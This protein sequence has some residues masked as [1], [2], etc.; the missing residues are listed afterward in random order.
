MV[1][2]YEP[3]D[4]HWAPPP[5][6]PF[7]EEVGADPGPAADRGHRRD[8]DRASASIRGSSRS[9]ASAADALAGLGHDVIE[10][11]PPWRRRERAARVR[12]PVVDR[13]G[14]VPG[15]G[16]L[17]A[18]AAEPR[19]RERGRCASSADYA[20]AV[21]WFQGFARRVVAF[22]ADVDVVLTP[23][24]GMLPVEIGWVTA[25]DDPWEQYRRAGQFT[26]FT[27][28][29]NVTGQPAASVPWTLVDGLP[30]G[31]QLI[32]P[33]AGEALLIRLSSQLEDAYPWARR[34][35]HPEG[36]LGRVSIRGVPRAAR[37]TVQRV[38]NIVRLERELATVELKKKLQELGIGAG[39]LGLPRTRAA[40][41][42]FRSSRSRRDRAR[43][44]VVGGA[45][46]HDRRA[47]LIAAC[48]RY[49]GV[50][51]REEGLA[52]AADAGDR[53]SAAHEG[54]AEA[55]STT[56]IAHRGDPRRDRDSSAELARSVGSCAPRRTS[57]SVRRNASAS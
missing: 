46:D 31:I 33:P 10:A 11:T 41:V 40:G 13:S 32:G 30:A 7:L 52:P 27:P 23:A 21:G 56:R 2:G 26:P 3:G 14:A 5:E 43:P 12:A 24:L 49:L 9:P 29:V 53:G 50:Q 48:S 47:F 39:L 35:R 51:A 22:W 42:A 1:A 16:P 54:G 4:P 19:A 57:S 36:G 25:P 38:S 8:A 28:L 18:R 15:R 20:R 6:R 55:M 37:S 17:A 44:A 45:A 34:S